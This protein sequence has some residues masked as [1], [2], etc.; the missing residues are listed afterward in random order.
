MCGASSIRPSSIFRRIDMDGE[1]RER[2]QFLLE[3]L[4]CPNCAAKMEEEI[5]RE[6]GLETHVDFTQRKLSIL[7]EKEALQDVYPVIERVVHRHESDVVI[8]PIRK[9]GKAEEVRDEKEEKKKLILWLMIPVGL[10][11]AVPGAF[12]HG[13]WR[14]LFFGIAWFL[15]GYPILRQAVLGI[16]KR[17]VFN[18]Y[19]LMTVATIGAFFLGEYMEAVGVMLFFRIGE[20]FEDRA[21][22]RSR[23][24]ILSLLELKVPVSHI[25][26]GEK[27]VDMDPEEVHP[28]MVCLVKAGERI[29]LDGTILEGESSIDT[30]PVTGEA[31]PLEVKSGDTVY[32]G[33]VNLRA[34]LHVRVEKPYEESMVAGILRMVEEAGEKKAPE[35]QFIRR[36][37]RVYTPV[38]LLLALLLV[39][40]P[41]LIH[42]ALFP[43]FLKR[44]LIFLVVSCPCALVLSIPLSFFAGIGSMSRQGILVKG[45]SYISLLSKAGIILWDKTGTLTTGRFVVKKL[46]SWKKDSDEEELLRLMAAAEAGSNH[47]IARSVL[48][49]AKKRNLEFPE[50]SSAEEIPGRGLMAVV[51]GIRYYAGQRAL[52]EDLGLPL[53]EEEEAGSRNI[54]L[55]TKEA[56]LL[57]VQIG[58]EAKK[59]S[60][61]AIEALRRS[62]IRRQVLLSGD[63]G[64]EASAQAEKL[65]LDEAHGDLLPEDKLKYMEECMTSGKPAAGPVIFVGDGINDAPSLRRADIGVAMGAMGS[66]AAMEA[67]DIV[68]MTDEP[69]LLV[70][71]R[72]MA[73]RTHGIAW[74]NILF[75][76]AVKLI[77]LILGALGLANLWMA[78]FADVGVTLLAVLNSMR[79][80]KTVS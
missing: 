30:S 8:R 9:D 77:V 34:M 38:V 36:F 75:A 22:D 69:S 12:L 29:P 35:E 63:K 5:G 49:E 17:D 73:R 55:A 51:N 45:G 32:S 6:T 66:D 59:D 64:P 74:V 28:G 50:A 79:C 3:G 2:L 13:G 39:L 80:L 25:L 54:Y 16:L 56:I 47:P 23:E 14:M 70:K 62:G 42:P 20:F 27:T 24:S 60:K 46:K 71:A 43:D 78:V 76:I 33:T 65:G 57:T 31:F 40:I 18:E 58:D 72:R 41:T 37:A 61:E 21:V 15:I 26:M 4:G 10:I 44:G 68:L 52:M 7:G 1:K 48:E 67:A 19:T 11:F 53:P